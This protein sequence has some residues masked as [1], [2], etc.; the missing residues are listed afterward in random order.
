MGESELWRGTNGA[1]DAVSVS[2]AVELCN[3]PNQIGL[4]AVT[5][6]QASGSEQLVG[7][8]V[9]CCTPSAS[10]WSVTVRGT[11]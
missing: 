10:G 4:A 6:R 3:V 5:G 7:K 1:Q 9:A 11:E 2:S 8:T